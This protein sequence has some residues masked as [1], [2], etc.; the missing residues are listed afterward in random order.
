ME[1]TAV[2]RFNSYSA[3]HPKFVDAQRRRRKGGIRK[4][5]SR[6]S[7]ASTAGA[8]AARKSREQGAYNPWVERRVESVSLGRLLKTFFNGLVRGGMT[9]FV[10]H[11]RPPFDVA[12]LTA[13]NPNPPCAGTRSD[14]RSS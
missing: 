1:L 7:V 11:M 9:G 5:S 14:L 3:L 2:T 6:S 12:P 10:G 8:V 13:A 4:D